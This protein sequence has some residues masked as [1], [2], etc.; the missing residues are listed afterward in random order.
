MFTI[1]GREWAASV[2]P[3]FRRQAGSLPAALDAM[4][5]VLRER[6]DLV[7][8][9]APPPKLDLLQAWAMQD[10]W[11]G[12]FQRL[13]AVEQAAPGRQLQELMSRE[14]QARDVLDDA[15][16]RAM[17]EKASP[18]D[19]SRWATAL[20]AWTRASARLREEAEALRRVELEERADRIWTRRALRL[21]QELLREYGSLGAQYRILVRRL[22]SAEMRL[23][24]AEASGRMI[25]AAEYAELARTVRDLVAQ[26][27]KHTEATR[28]EA[29]RVEVQQAVATT[30]SIVERR[31][32]DRPTL[33]AEVVREVRQ[34]IEGAA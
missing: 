32:A 19:V 5:V 6:R 24:R 26:L 23:E 4:L 33:W 28:T 12:R 1:T 10:D 20:E 9:V 30:L 25:D 13:Q 18:A 27:Q 8:A 31:L 15:Y 17:D 2:Y 16:R 7:P 21:E 3:H 34:A 22:V 11:E 14:R 29:V